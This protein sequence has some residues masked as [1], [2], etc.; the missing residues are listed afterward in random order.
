MLSC[1]LSNVSEIK[2]AALG[3]FFAKLP[4]NGPKMAAR[5]MGTQPAS[6]PVSG[7]NFVLTDAQKEVFILIRS[8]I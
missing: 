1:I 5:S 4:R 2:M 3:R 6:D 8:K 7:I